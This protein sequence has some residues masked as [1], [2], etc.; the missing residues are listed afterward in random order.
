MSH[1]DSEASIGEDSFMDTVAN[2]V[3]ILI[4]FVVLTIARSKPAAIE[5]A[6]REMEANKAAMAQ[7]IDKAMSLTEDLHRLDEQ[8]NHHAMEVEF[9]KA[10][11]DLMMDQVHLTQQAIEER[12]QD[13]DAKARENLEVNQA[14]NALELQREQLQQQSQ[15]VAQAKSSTVVLKHLP[16][17][18]AKT[19][20]T[21]E[22]H[23]MM[24]GGRVAVIPWDNLI[25][26][27]KRNVELAVQRNTRKEQIQ[28]RL[29]RSVAS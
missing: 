3:G 9:R 17:P 21:K 4:I 29:G 28:D 26:A 13:L 10:E 7:P 14:L 27:L 25:E 20:F 8:M 19:V 24:K 18:M 15:Q 2:L 22:I 5:A 1:H 16:T 12:S 11:R 6:T 23:L